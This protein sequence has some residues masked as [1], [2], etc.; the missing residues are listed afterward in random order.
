M[1]VQITYSSQGRGNTVPY[2]PLTDEIRH[3]HG[4]V[5]L[6]GNPTAVADLPET[7]LSVAMGELLVALAQP[8]SALVSLGCDLG[9]HSDPNSRSETRRRAGGYVQIADARFKDAEGDFLKRAAAH[10]E[11]ALRSGSGADRWMVRF[12]LCGVAYEFASR[13]EAHSIW[14]WFDAKANTPAKAK[15]SRERLLGCLAAAVRTF[16]HG[17]D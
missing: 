12:D 6:R 8:S 2:P 11:T 5:D 17:A 16:P 4:Y 10:L 1:P 15:A 14:I 13:I 9:E 7:H 3:N